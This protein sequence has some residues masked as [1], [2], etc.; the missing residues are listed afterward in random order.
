MYELI[1]YHSGVVDELIKNKTL[2][3]FFDSINT[4]AGNNV[5]SNGFHYMAKV[6]LILNQ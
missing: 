6:S 1:R 4:G 5:I 3:Q 2:A